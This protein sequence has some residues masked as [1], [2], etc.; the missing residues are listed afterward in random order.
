MVNFESSLAGF[1]WLDE[2]GRRAA[3]VILTYRQDCPIIVGHADWYAGNTAF[4]EG[5][6][7][8]VLDW[9]LVADTEALI[10]GF[11]ASAYGASARSGGG[12]S[13]PEEVVDFL[14]D[15]EEARHPSILRR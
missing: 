1:E 14:H 15:Y 7:V 3:Q 10:A 13:G 5:R 8:G 9:E 4:I 11:A 6:L 2:L 12:L